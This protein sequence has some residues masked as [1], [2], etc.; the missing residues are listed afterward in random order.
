MC[1]HSH[2]LTDV[3]WVSAAGYVKTSRLQVAY[4]ENGL[5]AHL[6]ARR[7]TCVLGALLRALLVGA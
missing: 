1:I 2:L 6:S 4:T 3:T 7:L 5:A